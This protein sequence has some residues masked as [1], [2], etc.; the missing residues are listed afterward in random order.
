MLMDLVTCSDE[1]LNLQRAMI[2][3]GTLFDV[4]LDDGSL[5]ANTLAVDGRA[6]GVVVGGQTGFLAF[7][8]VPQL[9][10]RHIKHTLRL[11]RVHR[12]PIFGPRLRQSWAMRA[13][14][15]PD[16]PDWIPKI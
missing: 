12:M 2:Q 1:S 13:G 3:R 11:S 8:D 15:S 14:A 7:A 9:S 4:I 6:V 10:S 16:W 5:V